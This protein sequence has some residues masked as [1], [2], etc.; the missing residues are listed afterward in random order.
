MSSKEPSSEPNSSLAGQVKKYS[1]KLYLGA[2]MA[3]VMLAGVLGGRWVGGWF[4]REELGLI[5]GTFVGLA[6]GF[7]YFT[8]HMVRLLQDNSDT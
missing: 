4:D 1:Q 3:G 2:G 5:I 6:A 8:L 7:T